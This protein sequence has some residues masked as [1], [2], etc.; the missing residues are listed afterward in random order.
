MDPRYSA[1]HVESDLFRERSHAFSSVVAGRDVANLRQYRRCQDWRAAVGPCTGRLKRGGGG[2]R[3]GTDP[4]Y[5]SDGK[6]LFYAVGDKTKG[7]QLRLMQLEGDHRSRTLYYSNAQLSNPAPSPDG[8]YFAFV[9]AES[10]REEVYVRPVSGNEGKMQVSNNGETAPHWSKTGDHLFYVEGAA[11]V[12]VGVRSHPVL[13][14]AAPH[15]LFTMSSDLKGDYG[16][17]VT[18]DGQR[19]LVVRRADANQSAPVNLTVVQNW[20]A[21]FKDRQK[22]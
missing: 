21:E 6:S 3:R 7:F 9:S 15:K 22:Q 4:A 16:Y 17:D 12:E 13:A 2:A 5:S 1:R 8:L 20:F 19:F 11:I 18:A 10:G 14:L